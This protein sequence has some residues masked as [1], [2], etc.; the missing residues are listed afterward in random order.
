MSTVLWANLWVDGKVECQQADHYALYKFTSKL[1]SISKQLGVPSFRGI[2]DE[3]DIC[4]N[5]GQF[6]LPPGAESTND[7]MATD[8]VWIDL[9]EAIAM[10]E[11]V[12]THI[13]SKHIRFGLLRDFRAAVLEELSS[14]LGFVR[15]G[16]GRAQK[17]NFCIV[18]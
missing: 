12:Q 10:L 6:E 1:D 16:L 7:V 3:T 9:A 11:A 15:G 4:F 14:V 8:G 17:F 2:C 13:V 5:A 18:T